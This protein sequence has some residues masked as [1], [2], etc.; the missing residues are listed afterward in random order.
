MTREVPIPN[1]PLS[2]EEQAAVASLTI[3]DLAA[4]DSC[5][6]RHCGPDFLKVA[7]IVIR[8]ERELAPRFPSLSYVFY[9]VRLRHLV[10]SRRLDP[11][12]ISP[13][14]GSAKCGSQRQCRTERGS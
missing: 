2:M 13:T 14:C 11:Q 7:R 1:P 12:A 5:I 6:L 10:D 4:I 9:T 3:T 8:T